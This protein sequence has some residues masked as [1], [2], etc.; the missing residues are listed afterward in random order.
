MVRP[1]GS[2]TQEGKRWLAQLDRAQ[3]AVDLA[4]QRRDELVRQALS[5]NVGV[6]AVAEV[7]G[8]DKATVSR[9]YGTGGRHDV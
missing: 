9:R 8:I 1:S 5:G 7:L 6:R 3:R 2:E 4:T